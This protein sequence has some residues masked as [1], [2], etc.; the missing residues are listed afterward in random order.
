MRDWVEWAI[1]IAL[2]A[3]VWA[4]VFW[5]AATLLAGPAK[6]FGLLP[7]EAAVQRETRDLLVRIERL[8]R[9]QICTATVGYGGTTSA[10]RAL[11]WQEAD[12]EGLFEEAKR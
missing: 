10:K 11:A 8:L 7:K 6:A 5:A 4:V 12:C 9:V 1:A 2:A 3:C